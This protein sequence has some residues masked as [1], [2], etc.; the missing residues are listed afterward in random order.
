L[1]KTADDS[2]TEAM[3]SELAAETLLALPT[4]FTIEKA[5][6]NPFNPSVQVRYGLPEVADVNI[7]IYDLMGRLIN[8]ITLSNQP[9]G[10]HTYNW[11][12]TDLVGQKVSTGVYLLNMRAGTLLQQQKLTFLK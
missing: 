11:N 2:K 12:G 1:S 5:Y 6:P 8:K 4:E 10:W 3:R 9:A 7:Q